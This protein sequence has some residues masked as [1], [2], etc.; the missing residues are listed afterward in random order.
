MDFAAFEAR[1]ESVFDGI[2]DHRLK[3]HAGDESFKAIVVN[4]F[5]NLKLVPAETDDFD[6]EV[7]VDEFQLFAQ[8][9]KVS[10]LRKRRRRMLESLRTTPRAMSGSKRMKRGDGVER[11]EKE[12]GIDLGGERVHASFQQ[13]LL[14][15]FEVHLDARVVPNFYGHGDAHYGGEDDEQIV[16][17]VRRTKIEEEPTGGDGVPL[18]PIFLR[19]KRSK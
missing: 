8:R 12:V 13:E 19:L 18:V 10:C 5:E 1:G 17:P 4:V 3:Q 15:G 14:I 11:V 16:A 7:V 6:V 2:F 9:T